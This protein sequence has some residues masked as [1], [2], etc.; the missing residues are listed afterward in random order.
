MKEN[1]IALFNC[2]YKPLSWWL[3]A[4]SSVITVSDAAPS[5]PP[6][7]PDP[8]PAPPPAPSPAPPPAPPAALRCPWRYL[9]GKLLETKEQVGRCTTK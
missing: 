7:C 3:I 2:H 4:V 6:A 9:Q 5:G 8:P 1:F